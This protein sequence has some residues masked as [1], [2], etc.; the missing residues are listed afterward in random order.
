MAADPE[1][2]AAITG[3]FQAFNE[4]RFGDFAQGVTADHV[5]IYPQSGE[6]LVGRDVQKAFHEAFPN[7]PTFAI[8]N[9]LRDG[10][11]AV[12]ETDENY[13]DGSYLEDGVHP[14]AARRRGRPDDD[15]LRGALRSARMA[16]GILPGLAK[17][18][19]GTRTNR[20]Y[21]TKTAGAARTRLSTMFGY[22]RRIA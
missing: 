19:N 5:E 18:Q 21:A 13:P 1:F 16:E 9:I 3:A 7:P 10:N 17:A 14:R 22:S 2:S 6:V 12:V 8:R 4:R 15:V 20:P 11:L